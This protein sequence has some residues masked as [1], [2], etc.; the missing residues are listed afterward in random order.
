MYLV[1]INTTYKY[2][3]CI[4]LWIVAIDTTVAINTTY[5][6]LKCIRCWTALD[7]VCTKISQMQSS[8]Q[9]CFSTVLDKKF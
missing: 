7:R 8:L 9:T 6:Y 2:L 3:K 1:A 4:R 5:K